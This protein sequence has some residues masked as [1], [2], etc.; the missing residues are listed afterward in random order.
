[1]LRKSSNAV[2]SSNPFSLLSFTP[3]QSLLAAE[4]QKVVAYLSARIIIGLARSKINLNDSNGFRYFWHAQDLLSYKIDEVFQEIP[5]ELAFKFL[6]EH[7]RETM[8]LH[9]IED[10]K[11]DVEGQFLM[12]IDAGS[13]GTKLQF[14]EAMQRA[15]S[16]KNSE[17]MSHDDK[18]ANRD[19]N[20]IAEI[21]YAFIKCGAIASFRKFFG[22]MNADDRSKLIEKLGS[23]ML[24]YAIIFRRDDMAKELLQYNIDINR[25]YAERSRVLYYNTESGSTSLL[26][27]ALKR[28]ISDCV[29][30][31]GH[32]RAFYDQIVKFFATSKFSSA[33]I[34]PA[35][36]APDVDSRFKNDAAIISLLLLHGADPDIQGFNERH[37]AVFPASPQEPES[38]RRVLLPSPRLMCSELKRELVDAGENLI[39]DHDVGPI[40]VAKREDLIAL[41]DRV[42][43]LDVRPSNNV[44]EL[45]RP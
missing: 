43:N 13:V 39:D 25:L 22:K 19:M 24:E 14:Q 5:E 29:R 8:E 32:A 4:K 9:K 16:E 30:P 42:I 41:L 10:V 35:Y 3:E 15:L 6:E 11:E 31:V 7:K 1:M 26:N 44:T 34:L 20:S 17:E 38:I 23:R 21:I 12:L 2:L 28:S 40:A 33:E 37:V 36:Q 18:I 27:E 45:C